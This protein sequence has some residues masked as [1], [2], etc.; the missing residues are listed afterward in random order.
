MRLKKIAA[1]VL[2]LMCG[3]MP[4]NN[5]YINDSAVF[6]EEEY[7]KGSYDSMWYKN[8]GDYIEISD[9][10]ESATEVEIPS[11]IDGVPVTSIGVAAFDGCDFISVTIP[12]SV[13]SIGECAFGNCDS[14]TS[15]TIPDSVTNI[16]E[17]VF[18]GSELLTTV[19]LPDSVT[20]IGAKAFSECESLTSIIIPGSVTA[21]EKGMFVGC[22][23]LT[24]VVI[25]DG[26]TV[27]KEGAFEKCT[28]LTSITLPDSITS[29]EGYAFC[30]CSA[31]TSITIPDSVVSIG[32]EAFYSCDSLASITIENPGC[33][34]YDS[35]YTISNCYDDYYLTYFD[36]IICG[37]DNSTAQAH[38]EKFNYT[39]ESLGE[40]VEFLLGDA[41][42]D[43]VV[44]SSDASK[45]LSAYAT[46]A[47]GGESPLTKVQIKAAD[48]NCDGAVDSSDASS[49]LAYYAYIAT[50]GE[51]TLED[52]LSR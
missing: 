34:I 51:G 38:A 40:Y 25:R 12:D 8:Y 48:V 41:D 22:T 5:A 35:P 43:G 6:A 45:V 4:F 39:F 14:L 42:G 49:I 16:G 44:N 31:L 33:E 23:S 29:I 7:T 9:C 21:I 19:I 18:I 20:S 28:S 1:A 50:G 11:E 10:N 17:A 46:T 26:V 37:Y 13:T 24:S 32:T 52:F 30:D 47:T 27:I 2:T 15:L 36:G 3:A